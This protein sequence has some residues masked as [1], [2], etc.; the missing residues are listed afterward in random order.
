[1]NGMSSSIRLHLLGAAAV[2]LSL[3]QTPKPATHIDSA[4]VDAA[5]PKHAVML[6]HGAYRVMAIGR[7][8]DGQSE[9]HDNHT[10][11]VYF[12]DGTA[13][14]VTGGEIA[15]AKNTGP[16]EVRGTGITGG[17]RRTVSKGDVIAVPDGTPHFYT[18]IKAPVKYYLVKVQ[19]KDKGKPVSVVNFSKGGSLGSGGGYKIGAS[20]RDKD[21]IAE[22]HTRDTDIFYFI[23]GSA[24]LVTGGTVPDAK[25]SAAEEM[26]GAAI[27]GGVRQGR[28]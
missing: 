2:A 11:I 7:E 23:A 18:G 6:D 28:P 26:R 15:G 21:G 13:T 3:A 14:L 20:H 8:K 1:M 24:T 5:Y 10:D 19:T 22:I 4:K 25:S 12:V 16:G 17:E 27:S 9:I